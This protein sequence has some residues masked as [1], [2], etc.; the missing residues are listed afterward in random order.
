MLSIAIG[1]ASAFAHADAG[2]EPGSTS[3]HDAE[4][5]E[6]MLSLLADTDWDATYSDW[7][8]E[9]PGAQCRRGEPIVMDPLRAEQWCHACTA[10]LPDIQV[11]V[12]FHIGDLAR[13]SQCRLRELE[14]TA[15][16]AGAGAANLGSIAAIENTHRALIVAARQRFDVRQGS[17][18]IDWVERGSAF[19]SSTAVVWHTE[20]RVSYA[21]PRNPIGSGSRPPVVVLRS[22]DTAL[23]EHIGELDR[24]LAG[25]VPAYTSPWRDT[26]RSE[27]VAALAKA[28]PDAARL[29]ESPDGERWEIARAVRELLEQGN[30]TATARPRES[31]QSSKP[32]GSAELA[33]SRALALFAADFLAHAL[34][35]AHAPEQVGGLRYGT[36]SLGLP[37]LSFEIY[38]R[39]PGIDTVNLR[40]ESPLL[41]RI[42]DELPDTTWGR[43]AFLE[44]VRTGFRSAG[45]CN[46][47]SEEPFLLVIE[48]VEAALAHASASAHRAALLTYLAQAYETRW[49]V[50]RMTHFAFVSSELRK[51]GLNAER[52]RAT[53]RAAYRRIIEEFPNTEEATYA[54]DR[55]LRLESDL[56]PDQ[57][58]YLCLMGC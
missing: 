19:W 53:T 31:S 37:G 33:E 1:M 29:I 15:Q 34:E 27:L 17:A 44:L 16:P 55:L 51:L 43:Y 30:A 49:T 26:M 50:S 46:E 11:E 3:P 9:H 39:E 21:F 7:R 5:A 40:Y 2:P 41:A 48:R 18:F 24:K 32:D 14:V 54:R 25:A 42:A 6:Q 12:R 8:S 10:S 22:I 35:G 47:G 28:V 13:D 56:A 36:T 57:L 38:G 45:S 58:E 52:E 4:L 20:N 23:L